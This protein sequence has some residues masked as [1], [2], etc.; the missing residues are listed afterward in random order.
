MSFSR[1]CSECP[2]FPRFFFADDS[3]DERAVSKMQDVPESTSPGIPEVVVEIPEETTE[4]KKKK[5]KRKKAEEDERNVVVALRKSCMIPARKLNEVASADAEL[6]NN[7]E[8]LTCQERLRAVLYSIP[9]LVFLLCLVVADIGV[10]LI[11][12]LTEG[13]YDAWAE[14]ATT[15]ILSVFSLELL[16]RLMAIGW[17]LFSRVVINWIDVVII[18]CSWAIMIVLWQHFTN[19]EIDDFLLVM[20]IIPRGL[21]ALRL[22]WLIQGQ[23]S[24]QCRRCVGGH[25]RRFV[26]TTNF[27]DLDLS[28]VT[29][30]IIAMGVPS[31]GFVGYYRNPLTEVQRFFKMYH[32]DRYRIYNLCPELPYPSEAFEDRVVCFDIKDHTPPRLDQIFDFLEDAAVWMQD[33]QDPDHQ[34]IIAVHCKAGKGR[35][36]TMVCAWLLYTT[37]DPTSTDALERF[38]EKRTNMRESSKHL[39]GVDTPSQQRYIGYIEK[40]LAQTNSYLRLPPF[41]RPEAKTISL[42]SLTL[43]DIFVKPEK[44]KAL[45]AVISVVDTGGEW[46]DVY[47]SDIQFADQKIEFELGGTSVV[48][49]VRVTI[50]DQKQRGSCGFLGKPAKKG[51]K[52]QTPQKYTRAGDEKGALFFAIFHTA[53]AEESTFRVQAIGLDKAHKDKKQKHFKHDGHFIVSFTNGTDSIKSGSGRTDGEAEEMVSDEEN[54]VSDNEEVR[55]SDD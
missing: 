1:D 38:A 54:R 25:K 33:P 50:Y 13:S 12:V 14:T 40:W 53:F 45:R 20:Y 21:Y 23:C 31:A 29:P 24:V 47:Q 11:G 41:D 22:F 27:F 19:E 5:K 46:E 32:K 4:K 18:L 3:D 2:A 55:A 16:L 35:T 37:D 28:Y 43:H 49:D 17:H 39:Q 8:K 48:S 7:K 51:G 26:D 52:E 36:G 42:D 34:N 6:H 44:F 10:V 15:I 30:E 9:M